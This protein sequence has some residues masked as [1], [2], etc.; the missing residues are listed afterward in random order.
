[1][2]ISR[3]SALCALF[4]LSAC[5]TNYQREADDLQSKA[6]QDLAA[7]QEQAAADVNRIHAGDV[8]LDFQKLPDAQQEAKERAWLRSKPI[9]FL[10]LKPV[11]AFEIMKIF[12]DK[13]IN[14][15]SSL[16]LDTYTYSGL[17][18]RNVNAET[19]LNVLLSAMGLDYELDNDAQVVTIEPLKSQTWTINIGN[20]TTAYNSSTIDD[21]SDNSSSLATGSTGSSGSSYGTNG[22]QSNSGQRSGTQ[23]GNSNQNANSIN[24]TDNFWTSLSTELKDRLSVLLPASNAATTMPGTIAQQSQSTPTV[25]NIP[26]QGMRIGTTGQS[27]S[28]DSQPTGANNLYKP[29]LVGRYSYNPET[30][31]VTIQA[32]RWMMKGIAAYMNDVQTMYNTNITFQGE[33]VLIQTRTNE[34]R[35]L[36]IA[37][38]AKFASG[39]YGALLSNNVLG[40]TVSFPTS[41][42]LV[43]SLSTTSTTAAATATT[44]L[45]VTSPLDGL[46]IFNAYMKTQE[47]TKTIQKPIV[48]TT[49]GVPVEFNRLTTHHYTVYQQN[50]AAGGVSGNAT[51]ATQNI[52]VPYDLGTILRINPR[53]DV[54]S[55]IVRA[56]VFLKTQQQTGWD[57]STQFITFGEKAE[58]VPQNIPVIVRQVNSTETTLKDGDLVI[59][60]GLTEDDLDNTGNGVTGLKDMPGLSAIFGNENKTGTQTTMYFVMKVNLVKRS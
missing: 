60:G 30:G 54:H 45:G 52:L 25:P 37:N 3:I 34:T 23:S 43:P 15:T 51:V 16:P 13:G 58:Q 7:A 48:S 12:R 36:D 27:G 41:G 17:G 46:Q 38:F 32:P 28:H 50:S 42:S 57:T 59:L 14:V 44:L 21:S 29:E 55:G 1:M 22:T 19:A 2:K 9:T 8:P 47:N 26:M 11:N 39:R 18:V 20:R 24:I 5:A 56:Q 53:Y 35:G 4:A 49:S 40:T 10:P 31:A 33:I 6:K